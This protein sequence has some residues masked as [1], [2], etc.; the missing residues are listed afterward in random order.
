MPDMIAYGGD[1]NPEQY[2]PAFDPQAARLRDADEAAFAL[3]GVNTL[4]VGVFAWS[5]LQ[6]DEQRY[7]FSSLDETIDRAEAAGRQIVLATPSGAVP[8]WLATQ[9][10]DVLRTDFEGRRHTYGQRHNAC[11]SS[12]NYRRLA[13]GMA[14]ALARRYAGRASLAAWH[15]GNEYGGAC[16]CD[17]CAAGFRDWLRRRYGSLDA[18]NADWN[19]VFWSH[20]FTDW[21]QIV[22]PNALSEHWRGEDHTAFQGITLDYRRFMTDA[23]LDC[24]KAEKQAI[25]RY[26]ASTPV[27]TNLMGL[28]RPIDY[29]RWANELDFAAWDNYPPTMHDEARMALTHDLMRGLKGGAPFWVMEQTPSR[30][31]SRDVNPLKAPGVM[32]LWSWQAVAHGADA[33]CFFQMRASR[34]ACEKD[35][36]ALIGHSGRT[37]TRVFRE[38]AGLGAEFG[39]V[40]RHL[41][42]AT[43]PA[44]VALLFD[45]DSWWAMEM[46]DGPNRL[47]RYIDVQLAWYKA[48][49]RR[50]EPVDVLPVTSGLENYDLVLAP[51]LH[52]VKGDLAA[53][54]E[55]V[56]AHGGTVVTGCLSG[57]V[58]AS[59]NAFPMDDPGLL[60]GLAGLRV[61]ETDAREP[62]VA[63]PV[64]FAPDGPGRGEPLGTGSYVFDLIEPGEATQ[65]VATYDGDWFAG[66]PVVTRCQAP[67]STGECWYIGTD[68]DDGSL[69]KL[70]DLATRRFGWSGTLPV[71]GVERTLRRTADGCDIYFVLNHNDHPVEVPSPAGGRELITDAEIGPG[72]P[73]ALG[74]RGVAVIMGRQ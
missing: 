39:R 36:G 31:A 64:R 58:D 34:G 47:L 45:W 27:T 6:P 20:V 32:R 3:A 9:Y 37:D 69:D 21:G 46:A 55:A 71:A 41:A 14:A 7:D 29:H 44:R 74:P 1:Y 63:V 49:W 53:K 52:M 26:D 13:V 35:H 10:P 50:G 43:T 65:V 28:Y 48:M 70:F 11:P 66:T 60:A 56:V 40:G 22:P 67:D 2:G 18:L 61:E 16:Y 62:Q 33:V 15:I 5:L 30:T 38:A 23:L 19:T 42:G 17:N 51:L 54:L 4:T 25:R 72:Q 12:P 57:H 59:C 24:F 68:L 73:L 8:P